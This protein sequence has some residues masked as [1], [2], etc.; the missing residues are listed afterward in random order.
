[1]RE[2]ETTGFLKGTSN[3][4]GASLDKGFMPANRQNVENGS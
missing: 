1:M 3:N 4:F 2:L